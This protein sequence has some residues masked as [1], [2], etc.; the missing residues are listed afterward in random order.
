M[1]STLRNTPPSHVSHVTFSVY[2]PQPYAGMC[3][4]VVLSLSSFVSWYISHMRLQLTCE[5]TSYLP[6]SMLMQSLSLFGLELFIETTQLPFMLTYYLWPWDYSTT[7]ASVATC[8]Y[9]L[10]LWFRWYVRN[11]SVICALVISK[12]FIMC[13]VQ[14]KWPWIPGFVSVCVCVCV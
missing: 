5:A 3:S 8:H 7:S 1:F 4:I 2:P 12:P 13:M 14:V 6:P 11:S 10:Q 9:L